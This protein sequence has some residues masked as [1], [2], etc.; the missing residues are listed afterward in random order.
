MFVAC[1]IARPQILAPVAYSSPL[2]SAPLA[3]VGSSS[4]VVERTYHGNTSPY[5]AAP[6]AAYSAYSAPIV[7]GAYSGAPLAY[8]AYGSYYF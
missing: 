8:S 7:A 2:V 6:V 4:A 3:V 1:V 5:I